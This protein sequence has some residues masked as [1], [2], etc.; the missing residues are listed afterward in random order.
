PGTPPINSNR[1][2]SEVE[3]VAPNALSAPPSETKRV[4]GNALHLLRGGL[5][6]LDVPEQF[7]PLDRRGDRAR[8]HLLP[9]A[10]V[11]LDA[12]EDVARKNRQRLAIEADDRV[13]VVVLEQ[14]RVEV[15]EVVG[16]L[17]VLR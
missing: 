5:R 6:R 11:R 4:G 16:D 15:A 14:V 9:R 17:D 12:L 13:D 1:H 3:R 2:T 8:H 10:I 7:P